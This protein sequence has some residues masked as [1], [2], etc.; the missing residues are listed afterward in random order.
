M[1]MVLLK[2]MPLDK[3]DKTLYIT[4]LAFS[5]FFPID[6]ALFNSPGEI[7]VKLANY[8]FYLICY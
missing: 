4:C 1:L 3:R 6:I 7:T 2:S 5:T 8:Y